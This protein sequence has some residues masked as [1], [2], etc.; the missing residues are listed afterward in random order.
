M[1]KYMQKHQVVVGSDGLLTA[2]WRTSLL[3]VQPGYAGYV[4][5]SLESFWKVLDSLAPSPE[6]ERDI[7]EVITELEKHSESLRQHMGFDS[8]LRQ[9]IVNNIHSGIRNILQTAL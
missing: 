7:K 5:N 3:E 4:Q 9:A 6:K 1:T 2:A 8:G